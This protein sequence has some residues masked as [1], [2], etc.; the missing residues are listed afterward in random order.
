[1]KKLNLNSAMAEFNKGLLMEDMYAQEAL[2]LLKRYREVSSAGLKKHDSPK[3]F[4]TDSFNETFGVFKHTIVNNGKYSAY[5]EGY[6]DKNDHDQYIT[7]YC[8]DGSVSTYNLA[9]EVAEQKEGFKLTKNFILDLH[10]NVYTKGKD[11]QT[12]SK[13]SEFRDCSVMVGNRVCIDHEKIDKYI[14]IMC[15]K[16]N[17]QL[18]L[19][20]EHIGGLAHYYLVNIHPFVDGN[21]RTARALQLFYDCLFMLSGLKQLNNSEVSKFKKKVSTKKIYENRNEYYRILSLDDSLEK[22]T[23]FLKFL[24]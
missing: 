1:V 19:N 5:I 11:Y 16:L 20:G 17:K 7:N 6:T 10:R 13:K 15:E 12:I 18:P 21:G 23:E 2:E 8:I 14:G 9:E 3:F 22:E 4:L 24:Y